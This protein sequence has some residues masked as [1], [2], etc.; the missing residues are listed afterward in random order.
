MHAS[1]R[2]AAETAEERRI[3]AAEDMPSMPARLQRLEPAHDALE[4]ER[5]FV[6]VDGAGEGDAPGRTRDRAGTA[7][8]L[9]DEAARRD[10]PRAFRRERGKEPQVLPAHVLGGKLHLVGERDE[11]AGDGATLLLEAG[12]EAP[13]RCEAAGAA[14]GVGREVAEETGRLLEQVRPRTKEREVVRGETEGQPALAELAAA[15]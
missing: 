6:P 5:P 15:G 14:G 2:Q 10:H 13:G 9:F 8:G 7:P 12:A 4:L 1:A 3:A 11:A